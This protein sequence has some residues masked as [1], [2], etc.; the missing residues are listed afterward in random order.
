MAG[1]LA[2]RLADDRGGAFVEYIILVAVVALLS[3]MAFAGFGT[4]G[5]STV[6]RQAADMALMGL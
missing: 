4:D 6:N 2:E 5:A 1:S 3:I